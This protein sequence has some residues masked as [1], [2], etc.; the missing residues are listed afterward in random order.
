MTFAYHFSFR[1]CNEKP[2][3]Q[4]AKSQAFDSLNEPATNGN[5]VILYST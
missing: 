1:N 4:I 3:R 2:I 5:T